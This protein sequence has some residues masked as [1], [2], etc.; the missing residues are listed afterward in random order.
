MAFILNG[1]LR[2]FRIAW[3]IVQMDNRQISTFTCEQN[4]Y[5]PTDS[6][7]AASN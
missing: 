3:F 7:I 4:R 5:C 6:G 2:L 1:T